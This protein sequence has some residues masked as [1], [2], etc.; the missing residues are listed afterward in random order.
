MASTAEDHTH[1]SGGKHSHDHGHTH[2]HDDGGG[3]CG[4]GEGAMCG[5]IGPIGDVGASGRSFRVNG[6]DCAEEVAILQRV[7]APKLGGEEHLAFDVLN[8]RMTV[9]DTGKTLSDD[10]VIKAIG[11]TGMLAKVWDADTAEADH[12]ANLARQKRFTMLSGGFW[13]AGF[14]YHFAENGLTGALRLFSGHGAEPMPTVN[15]RAL[16]SF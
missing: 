6:L 9:L 3:C 15:N 1:A 4:S 14:L 10:E 16:S 11:E 2:S 7:L 5:D 13:L 12:A 8:A